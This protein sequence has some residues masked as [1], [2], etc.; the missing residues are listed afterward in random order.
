MV[1]F[2]SLFTLVASKE[3]WVKDVWE[4]E[5]GMVTWNPSFSRNFHDWEM[6]VVQNF[7]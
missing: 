7:I 3:A 4:A 1:S 2:P 5:E 6:D